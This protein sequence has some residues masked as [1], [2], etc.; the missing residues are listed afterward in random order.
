MLPSLAKGTL[1]MWFRVWIWD[2]RLSCII[3]WEQSKSHQS[4]KV[5]EG[6]GGTGQK[7]VMW[8]LDPLLQLWKMEKGGCEECG[9]PE[10]AWNTVYAGASRKE[11][12]FYTLILAQWDVWL[13]NYRTARWCILVVLSHSIRK[14]YRD[15]WH[16]FNSK[17]F[18]SEIIFFFYLPRF[19]LISFSNIL[20]CLSIDHVLFKNCEL[21]FVCVCVRKIGLELTS[22]INPPLF[23]EEDWP[24]ANICAHLPLFCMWDAATAWLDELCLSPHLRFEPA[25]PGP[26]KLSTQT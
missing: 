13:L 21:V 17:S 16:L 10:K 9:E 14:W 15:V 5:P 20:N 11:C 22:V 24:W 8:V 2:G 25:N 26:P 23:A 18:H 3:R 12:G 6:G 19:Y 7:D 4:S 1:H